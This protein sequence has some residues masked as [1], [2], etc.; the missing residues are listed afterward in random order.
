MRPARNEAHPRKGQAATAPGCCALGGARYESP[1]QTNATTSSIPC[2]CPRCG[3][4]AEL[5]PTAGDRADFAC[6]RC[7]EFSISD[8]DAAL[9]EHR[10]LA[11]A[12]MRFAE[13][14]GRRF[15]TRP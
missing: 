15:L 12:D 1:M 5:Q 8:T 4:A 14:D 11:Y 2:A 7:G 3:G 6:P 13:R 9:V 10:A